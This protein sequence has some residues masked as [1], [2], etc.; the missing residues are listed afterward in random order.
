MNGKQDS[1][2]DDVTLLYCPYSRNKWLLQQWGN[3]LENVTINIYN[4]IVR[5]LNN[6]F[7]NINPLHLMSKR[8]RYEKKFQPKRTKCFLILKICYFTL[9][10]QGIT[11]RISGTLPPTHPTC[12]TLNF[13]NK[14]SYDEEFLCDSKLVLAFLY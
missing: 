4:G 3:K 12:C 10:V 8:G 9:Y 6:F 7:Y 2:D 1:T 14:L 11:V 13:N 5:K